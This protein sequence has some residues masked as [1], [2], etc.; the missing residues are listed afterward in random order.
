M[1]PKLFILYDK[2]QNL[3][4]AEFKNY[5]AHSFLLGAVNPETDGNYFDRLIIGGVLKQT[6]TVLG[7]EGWLDMCKTN[8][9]P[10][11]IHDEFPFDWND[12]EIRQLRFFM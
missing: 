10:H 9:L 12:I 7:I 5:S 1:E 2:K 4:I 6:K 11:L 3:Y 8:Q